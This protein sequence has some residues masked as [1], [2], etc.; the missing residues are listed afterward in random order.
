MSKLFCFLIII[1]SVL[2]VILLLVHGMHCF[3]TNRM[4]VFKYILSRMWGIA[5]WVSEWKRIREECLWSVKEEYI[6]TLLA[7]HWP[8]HWVW[9]L[10]DTYR[11]NKKT[12]AHKEETGAEQMEDNYTYREQCPYAFCQNNEIKYVFISQVGQSMGNPYPSTVEER[13]HVSIESSFRNQNRLRQTAFHSSIIW[14]PRDC[15]LVLYL[16]S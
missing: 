8:W 4:H 7:P 15:W 5:E 14:E 11:L 16:A 1:N 9:N 13:D 10:M 12:S 6:W 2:F 3:I